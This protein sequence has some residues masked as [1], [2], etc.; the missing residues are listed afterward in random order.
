MEHN[1]PPTLFTSTQKLKSGLMAPSFCQADIITVVESQSSQESVIVAGRYYGNYMSS[2]E[3]LD[4][5]SSEWRT[6]PEFQFGINKTSMVEHPSGGVVLI[7]GDNGTYLDTL[8]HLPQA[9]SEWVLMSQ[10]LNVA[11]EFATA[12]LVQ[13]EITNCH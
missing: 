9:N 6:G 11:R 12:F 8:Y 13:D 5:G 1:T 3:I 2:V 10:K 4:L 7:G